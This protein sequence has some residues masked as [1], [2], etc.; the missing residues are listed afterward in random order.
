MASTKDM[1]EK[2]LEFQ[3]RTANDN[4]LSRKNE[5][6][7]THREIFLESFKSQQN[8]DCILQLHFSDWFSVIDLVIP[9]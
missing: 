7:V 5:G 4:R 2:Y 9:I 8:M 6:T 1:S 3:Q